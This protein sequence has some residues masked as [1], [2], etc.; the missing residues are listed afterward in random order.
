MLIRFFND[1]DLVGEKRLLIGIATPTADRGEA[2]EAVRVATWEDV[3]LY[4]SAYQAYRETCAAAPES[5]E[6]DSA[7][8]P[9][10]RRR[11]A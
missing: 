8:E 11:A 10:P 3:E 5:S 7:L 4:A 1:W 6:A 2:R 9:A